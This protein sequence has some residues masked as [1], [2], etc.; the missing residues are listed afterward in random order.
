M[1]T[2]YE[3][4]FSPSSCSGLLVSNQ[5]KTE[6]FNFCGNVDLKRF[7]TLIS[8]AEKAKP[9]YLV[10]FQLRS[11]VKTKTGCGQEL[12]KICLFTNKHLRSSHFQLLKCVMSLLDSAIVSIFS[13]IFQI[14]FKLGQL[15]CCSKVDF[16]LFLH[17]HLADAFI[18]SDLQLH[19]G[20]TFLLV[21]VFPG[22]RT[23]NLSLSWRNVLPLSHTGTLCVPPTFSSRR[24]PY[25]FPICS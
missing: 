24:F 19:S 18:Q 13:I 3:N 25:H 1:Q 6:A 11:L 21:H 20:Y 5:Q 12:P 8:S 9:Y 22:N 14:I 10:S 2:N 7:E 17:L 15:W 4:Q 23:H 16:C